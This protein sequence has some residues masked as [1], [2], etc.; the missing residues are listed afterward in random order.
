[1]IIDLIGV[2]M[3]FGAG[4]RGVDMGPS[5]ISIA[6]LR[7][8]LETLGHEVNELGNLDIPLPETSRTRAPGLRYADAIAA[9]LYRFA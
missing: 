8:R 4:R 2:P 5:A 6:G 9:V 7:E 3:D 1:M